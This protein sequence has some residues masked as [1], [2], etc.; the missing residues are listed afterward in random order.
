[1]GH[2]CTPAA[3]KLNPWIRASLSPK[4][5]LLRAFLSLHQ[6]QRL[7]QHATGYPGMINFLRKI[8]LKFNLLNQ[9]PDLINGGQL[10]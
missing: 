7:F 5:M 6:L 1:M 9:S 10:F 8:I 3:T 4:A 2:A